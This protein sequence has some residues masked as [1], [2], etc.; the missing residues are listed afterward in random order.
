MPNKVVCL[1]GLI[2]FLNSDLCERF[3]EK[4]LCK[5]SEKITNKYFGN[6]NGDEILNLIWE[7]LNAIS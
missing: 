4:E 6:V 7:E 3:D 2:H 1:K 5:I